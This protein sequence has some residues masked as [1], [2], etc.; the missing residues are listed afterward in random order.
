MAGIAGFV[1]GAFNDSFPRELFVPPL[2]LSF[3]V[4]YSIEAFTSRLDAI[5]H[6]LKKGEPELTAHPQHGD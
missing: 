1:I 2:A 4:G 5:I 3:L 6:K